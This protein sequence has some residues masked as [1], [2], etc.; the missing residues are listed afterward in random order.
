MTAEDIIKKVDEIE[1]TDFVTPTFGRHWPDH[2]K[3]H[4]DIDAIIH[5]AHKQGRRAILLERAIGDLVA[6]IERL[7]HRIKGLEGSIAGI[8]NNTRSL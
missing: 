4:N 1:Q 8:Y 6:E 2:V 3:K 7:N 5:I